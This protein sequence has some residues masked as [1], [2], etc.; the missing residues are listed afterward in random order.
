MGS[1]S[2]ATIFDWRVGRLET[3]GQRGGR[4]QKTHAQQ[5]L[6]LSS[7]PV[8][9]KTMKRQVALAFD[10]ADL[11]LNVTRARRTDNFLEVGPCR[12]AREMTKCRM[13]P[14]AIQAI[15]T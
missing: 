5:P 1:A 2:A 13:A 9:A 10:H 14:C 3:C 11:E 8:G 15:N 7:G 12:S 4:G 6:R